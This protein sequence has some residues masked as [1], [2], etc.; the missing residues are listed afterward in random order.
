MTLFEANPD[1][2]RSADR[3]GLLPFH[4]A[5]FRYCIVEKK[6]K[7]PKMFDITIRRLSHSTSLDGGDRRSEAD[8]QDAHEI[9]ILYHLLKADPTVL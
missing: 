4:I 1:A 3:S 6:T 2:M 8:I 7:C 5:C 9:E